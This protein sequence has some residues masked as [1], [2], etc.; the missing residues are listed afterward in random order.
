M[1][2]DEPPRP[3]IEDVL[4]LLGLLRKSAAEFQEQ[5]D[6]Y[7][8]NAEGWQSIRS[9]F[10]S[11]EARFVSLEIRLATAHPEPDWQDSELMYMLNELRDVGDDFTQMRQEF[12]K[13]LQETPKRIN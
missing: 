6:V 11:F 10:A 8:A 3:T 13:A 5:I 12:L 9:R 7:F 4:E 1:T 2:E